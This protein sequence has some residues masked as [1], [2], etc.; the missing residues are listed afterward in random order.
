MSK[1]EDHKTR[2]KAVTAGKVKQAGIKLGGD[3]KFEKNP[4]FLD[5]RVAIWEKFYNEQQKVYEGK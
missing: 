4:K 1:K 2:T 5:D 3:L